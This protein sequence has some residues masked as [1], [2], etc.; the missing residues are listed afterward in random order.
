MEL[1][2]INPVLKGVPYK[3]V[4]IK[5]IRK[6]ITIWFTLLIAVVIAIIV[7]ITAVLFTKRFAEQ[8]NNIVYGNMAIIVDTIE[9]RIDSY[10]NLIPVIRND[11]LLRS[12]VNAG[13]DYADVNKR[14][15]EISMH[16]FGLQSAFEITPDLKVLDPVYSQ[17]S[18]SDRLFQVTNFYEF[19]KTGREEMFSLPHGFPALDTPAVYNSRL[20]YFS[21]LRE[22][23]GYDIYGYLLIN[24]ECSSL[25]MDQ[26]DLIDSMFESFYVMDTRGNVIYSTE[27]GDSKVLQTAKQVAAQHQLR[28]S[29]RVV[30]AD[31]YFRSPIPTYP[32]WVIIGVAS[33]A[34][35]MRDTLWMMLLIVF[36]GLMS[37]FLVVLFSNMISKK[38]TEPIYDIKNAM[39]KFQSGE[40]PDKLIPKTDD[41]LAFLLTGF[42]SMLDDISAYINAIYI[43]QE[44]KKNADIAA[45]KY[46][47]ESLQS[48]IN[49]HFLYNTLNTVSY[50]ALT[51]R[52]DDIR[53]LIQS[54][55]ML[56]RSTLSNNNEFVPVS[57]ELS[58]LNSYVSI[59]KYRYPQMVTLIL[60]V[61]ESL[62][63]CLV[64]KLILQ[65]LVENAML[66][67]I[68]P[69][70]KEGVIEVRI[71]KDE[72]AL[73]I[74]I[75]DSGAGIDKEKLSTLFDKAK[76][77]NS[78]GLTNVDER[79]KL[80][81]GSGSTLS[82][83][84]EKGR[85]TTVSFH[86]PIQYKE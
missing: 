18:F 67:G 51:E 80:Y 4:R 84:S 11:M 35:L 30:G 63:S 29:H 33:N 52:C 56:L 60:N 68:F 13:K 2:V 15:N 32:N 1:I 19:L 58:F 61:D 54:L 79:L 50:L 7:A 23:P 49:P 70:A 25:F 77:F 10:R 8:K 20:S 36:T 66:H 78:I 28:T 37:I 5:S 48:Q 9:S 14:L 53:S 6:R 62:S 26:D 31:T 86:I 71:Y 47:L 40:M 45:L 22:R 69:T 75:K 72:D 21:R 24:L 83:K 27:P 64:P 41:E 65:P 76:G 73:C 12:A 59:Q 16:V 81:Y 44:E 55:N 39:L 3:Q 34:S 82:I 42:N 74:E 57:K 17:S 43:E 38:I 46:Q 85:G